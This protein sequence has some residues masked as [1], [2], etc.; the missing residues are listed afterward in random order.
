MLAPKRV[1][2]RKMQREEPTEQRT[3]ALRSAMVSMG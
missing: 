1:K 3:V 2:H